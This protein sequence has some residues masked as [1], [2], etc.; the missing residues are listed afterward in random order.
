MFA[1]REGFPRR[2]CQVPIWS[3]SKK[4]I[5][6]ACVAF[7]L[8]GAAPGASAQAPA[9]IE[10]ARQ[11]TQK[12]GAEILRDFADFLSHPDVA[13]DLPANHKDIDDNAAIIKVKLEQR[14]VTAQILNVE[15]SFP[16]VY[17]EIKV[18]NAKLTVGIYAHFDGQPVEGQPWATPPFQPVLRKGKLEAN[19]PTVAFASLTSPL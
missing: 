4:V 13:R 7:M 1:M 15:K 14:G 19:A 17:G 5:V 9:S 2:S 6:Y 10:A 18:P 11:Y 16:A 12:N 8:L 3:S